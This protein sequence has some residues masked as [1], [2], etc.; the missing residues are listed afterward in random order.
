MFDLISI[1]NI[2]VDLFYQGET[3]TH[4]GNR[5]NLAI[6]GKY[7]VDHFYETLGGGGANVAIGVN[8]HGLKSAIIGVI[9]NNQFK[10]IILQHLEEHKVSHEF[11]T[12]KDEYLKISSILL[13]LSGERTIINYETPHEHI[14]EKTENFLQLKKAKMVYM[15]NLPRVP[16]EERVHV[17]TYLHGNNIPTILNFGI[18]DCRRPITQVLPLIHKAS[19][20]MVNTHEFAELAKK[21]YEDIDFNKDVRKF[22]HSSYNQTLIVTD[23]EKGSYGYVGKAVHYIRALIPHKI[24]DTTG[25]GDAYTAGFIAGYLKSEGNVLTSME[26]GAKYAVK[27]LEKV[28]AN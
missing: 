5:F 11:C 19:I 23:G 22:I 9:G 4:S 25:A 14:F 16:L 28:G 24:I 2:S 13:S 7:L 8:R 15:S 26:T 1:G 21:R 27:I 6:G 18:K 3:L 10:K 12:F 17:L 20:L